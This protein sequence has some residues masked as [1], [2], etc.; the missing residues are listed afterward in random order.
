MLQLKTLHAT[1]KTQHSQLND[2]LKTE[3]CSSVIK[4]KLQH[5]RERKKNTKILF[6]KF[7]WLIAK[8]FS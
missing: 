3:V 5:F 6:C 1:A 7:S 8:N 2:C 4:R